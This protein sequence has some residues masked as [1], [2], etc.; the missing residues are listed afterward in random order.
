MA[1]HH[2]PRTRLTVAGFAALVL[3][4]TSIATVAAGKPPSVPGELVVKIAPGRTPEEVAEVVGGSV[5]SAV[6]ASRGIV[7]LDVPFETDETEPDKIADDWK[8]A[9]KDAIKVLVDG[10]HAVYAERNYDTGLADSSRFHYWPDDSRPIEEATADEYRSQPALAA[11]GLD[12]APNSG[13]GGTVVAVL[14]TGIDV[15]HPAFAGRIHPAS[16]DYV[17]DDGDP[18]D[19]GNDVDDD[20][21]GRVDEGVGHGTH[22]AGIVSLVAP[23]TTILALRVIDSDGAGF[24]FTVAEAIRDAVDLD[25]DVISM[26]FGMHEKMPSD[27]LKDAIKSAKDADI[28]IVAAAGN[29]ASEDHQYP[30]A[31]KEV[32]SVGALGA[33]GQ[34]LATFSNRGDWVVVAAPGEHIVSTIPG[35]YGRW[36]GTSMAAPWVAGQYADLRAGFPRAEPKDVVESIRKTSRDVEHAKLHEGAVDVGRSRLRMLDKFS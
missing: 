24:A 7:L 18:S 11:L 2:S 10:G 13:G 15:A 19:V 5:G 9:S 8:D 33:D 17:D 35:G 22:A 30:A 16:Y 26:S 31:N 29:E 34:N 3:L 23:Q 20:G 36:S 6:L 4:A 21:D 12:G 25:V 14:D 27:V 1:G 32:L 28:P